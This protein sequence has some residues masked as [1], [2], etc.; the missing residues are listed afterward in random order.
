MSKALAFIVSITKTEQEMKRLLISLLAA[1]ALPS[2]VNAGT[3][4]LVLTKENNGSALEN[5]EMKDLNQS[6][7]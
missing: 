1:F 7:L 5:I 2:S 3:Y 6:K 4:W